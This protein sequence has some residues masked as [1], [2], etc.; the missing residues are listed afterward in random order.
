MFSLID[1]RDN[2]IVMS[3]ESD[4]VLNRFVKQRKKH[5]RHRHTHAENGGMSSWSDA[6]PLRGSPASI[7][8]RLTTLHHVYPRGDN[9]MHPIQ[10]D[11]YRA[12]EVL[13]G[14]PWTHRADIWNIV[15]LVSSPSPLSC[16]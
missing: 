1:I 9:N 7:L 16:M 11:R 8:P 10:A 5:S 14:C 12:P 2:N 15:V 4:A 6:G 13:L 3:L